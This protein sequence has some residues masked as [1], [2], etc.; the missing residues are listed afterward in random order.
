MSTD[1]NNLGPLSSLRTSLYCWKFLSPEEP[2]GKEFW[3]FLMTFWQ[4]LTGSKFEADT[5][6]VFA[7][8]LSMLWFVILGLSQESGGCEQW[9]FVFISQ[10][11]QWNKQTQN[12]PQ[13]AMKYLVPNEFTYLLGHQIKDLVFPNSQILTLPKF[14]K[15]VKW[16]FQPGTGW[17]ESTRLQEL[18]Q[19]KW[20]LLRLPLFPSKIPRK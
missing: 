12:H 11:C 14:K 6:G 2:W 7:S 10:T 3:Y 20:I 16:Q 4:L 19:R 9:G 15:K 1:S 5:E 13:Q 18:I 8:S 17:Q